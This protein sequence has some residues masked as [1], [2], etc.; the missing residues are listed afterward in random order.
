MG[1]EFWYEKENLMRKKIIAILLAM[2]ML[3]IA[4]CGGGKTNNTTNNTEPVAA[5]SDLELHNISPNLELGKEVDYKTACKIDT[6]QTTVG[7]LKISEQNIYKFGDALPNENL[8]PLEEYE[9]IEVKAETVFADQNAMDYG[10]NRASCVS[11]YYD[12]E[13]YELRVA[14]A[15]NGFTKFSVK[16]G[17]KAYNDCLYIKT[18][19]NQGWNTDLQSICNYTWYLRVPVGYDGMVIVFFNGG[20]D[21]QDGQYIYEVLDTDAR[22]YRVRG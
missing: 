4:G 5:V 17:D 3:L 9:W 10:V 16:V 8:Q 1:L 22:V 21:W 15:E 14:E 6:T 2:S 12:L 18:I 11:N 20:L 13:Y 7:K 19:D